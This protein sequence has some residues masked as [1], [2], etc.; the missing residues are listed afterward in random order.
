MTTPSHEL[1]AI[2]RYNSRLI[3]RK[4]DYSWHHLLSVLGFSL[5]GTGTSAGIEI[6][7]GRGAIII[8]ELTPIALLPWGA[9]HNSLEGLKLDDHHG[10]GCDWTSETKKFGGIRL[11]HTIRTFIL[12]PFAQTLNWAPNFIDLI[13]QIFIFSVDKNGLG[14]L[15]TFFLD[16]LIPVLFQMTVY[17]EGVNVC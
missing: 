5:I 4:G 13:V 3:Q 11:M 17:Q 9:G 15:L 14:D 12:Q 1:R 6:K 16:I 8:F 7:E 2:P 10:V